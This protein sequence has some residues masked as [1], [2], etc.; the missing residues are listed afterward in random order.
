MWGAMIQQY[1]EAFAYWW[2]PMRQLR[3]AN[4]GLPIAW[5]TD[6]PPVPGRPIPALY[7]FV[8]RKAIMIDSEVPDWEAAKAITVEE[9]LRMMTIEAAY[10]LF[11]EDNIGSLKPGKFADLVVLSENPLTIDPD[12]IMNID[13]L[14]TMVGGNVEYYAPGQ[15][16]LCPATP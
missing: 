10:A 5:H 12:D 11:M 4:P 3:D 1:P 2:R 9:A 6:R 14:L 7:V 13:V 15:E 16:A 8:T